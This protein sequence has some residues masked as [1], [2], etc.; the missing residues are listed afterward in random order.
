M[1][2][3]SLQE[4]EVETEAIEEPSQPTEDV[5]KEVEQ[6][7]AEQVE[8]ESE[9]TEEP[10]KDELIPV[11]KLE[12]E[13]S[14]MQRRIDRQT[15]ANREL[16]EKVQALQEQLSKIKPVESESDEPKEEDYESFEEFDQARVEHKAEKLA[17]EKERAF[18]QK[19]LAEQQHKLMQAKREEFESRK[20]QFRTEV[21]DYDEREQSFN[22]IA[23]YYQQKLGDN[24]TLKAVGQ[25]ILESDVS[26]QII[27]QLG[28]D[29]DVVDE[30]VG[31][32]PIKAVRKLFELE[33]AFSAKKPEKKQPPKPIESL[34]GK[35]KGTK[36]L[37]NMSPEEALA[38]VNS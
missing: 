25:Y 30:I 22:E 1:T 23:A 3:N 6:D 2:D 13:K 12:H 24:E 36:T 26:P 7:E 17:A 21:S 4:A 32:S 38:W 35:S 33:N 27:Y 18:K 28:S 34:K 9:Q 31:L 16:N 14:S 37:A 11:S 20:S 5:K 10:K 8:A 19:Q 29:P 15:A